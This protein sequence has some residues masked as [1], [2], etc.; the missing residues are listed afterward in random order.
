[1]KQGRNISSRHPWDK[2]S[3]CWY[4]WLELNKTKFFNRSI[5]VFQPKTRQNKK[6]ES[7]KPASN[8]SY[9]L[10]PFIRTH[11]NTTPRRFPQK[12]LPRVL[13]LK[14]AVELRAF[15]WPQQQPQ[16]EQLWWQHSDPRCGL[17]WV[18]GRNTRKMESLFDSFCFGNYQEDFFG[19]L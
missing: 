9:H 1:M 15:Q 7:Q 10:Q 19:S 3:S 18:H 2:R 12:Q 14:Q 4:F 16:L 5:S 8:P 17:A 13:S 6:I 11:L